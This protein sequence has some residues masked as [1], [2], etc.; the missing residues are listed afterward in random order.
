MNRWLLLQ[1]GMLSLAFSLATFFFGWWAVPCLACFWCLY[2]KAEH[3]PALIASLSAGLGWAF[4]LVWTA[5][6]GPVL[7][8]ASRASGVMGVP[9]VALITLT[10]MFPMALAWGAGVVAGTVR[11][12]WERRR[13]GA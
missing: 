5:T 4:L 2:D 11:L 13:Q 12:L 8:L 3:R 1:V 10:L 9:S 7:L 6:R